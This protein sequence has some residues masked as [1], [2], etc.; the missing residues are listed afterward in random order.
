MPMLLY[1]QSAP[2]PPESFYQFLQNGELIR[3]IYA[4]GDEFNGDTLDRV[5]WGT[6]YPWGNTLI[7]NKELERYT[8]DI[9]NIF[10]QNGML[11]L[12]ARYEP[13]YKRVEHW[14]ADN[15]I[16][17]DGQPNY[18]FFPYTSG[19]IYSNESFL[20]GLYEIR[21]KTAY[22]SKGLWP[23]FWLY[24]GDCLAEIDFTEMKGERPNQTHYG[25]VC[26]NDC[27]G[28]N[29]CGGA[30]KT[31]TGNF[32]D[33]F[34][35][36]QGDWQSDGTV[37]MLNGQAYG[38]KDHHFTRRM[39]IIANLAVASDN[40]AFDPGP[41]ASTVFPSTL[42][43]DYIRAWSRVDCTEPIWLPFMSQTPYSPSPVTGRYVELGGSPIPAQK[44]WVPYGE[45]LTVL[46]TEYVK[47]LP[48]F[49]CFNG[50]RFYA[51]VAPCPLPPQKGK[52][53]ESGK[54]SAGDY[55]TEDPLK[56]EQDPT[57]S[58]PQDDQKVVFTATVFPNPGSGQIT[59]TFNG[60]SDRYFKIELFS[61]TGALVYQNENIGGPS[62]VIDASGFGKGVYY[63]KCT[64]G[65]NSVFQKVILE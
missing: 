62:I 35:V 46:A 31:A 60:K 51:N 48:G 28:T 9:S 53:D 30:W 7:K 54:E 44:A 20:Y 43:I 61:T 3:W 55:R 13:G 34:N 59:V 41:D 5:K 23:A 11:N 21:L 2:P 57:G 22:T 47:L 8:S 1:S 37:F 33:G 63:L 32:A 6:E 45:N 40:G 25:V 4:G 64:F 39:N 19:M 42:Q 29:D 18:R 10:L 56:I 26:D 15:K 58:L 36:I 38:Q 14:S 49:Q 65:A 27:N 24:S 17:S 50:G 12:V 16:L 52:R